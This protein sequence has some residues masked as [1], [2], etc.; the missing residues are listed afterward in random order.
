VAKRVNSSNAPLTACNVPVRAPA[1]INL[2]LHVLGR[3][4]DG[5]HVLDSLMVPIGLYDELTINITSDDQR[6]TKRSAIVVTSDSDAAPDGPTNL[7]YRAAELLLDEVTRSIAVRVHIAKRIPVGSGLG[8]GSSDA[9]AVLL[10]LND[11]LGKPYNTAE[12]AALGGRIGADVSFFVYGR[13]ARVGGIGE[14]ITPLEAW[15]ALP[16]VVCSDG[17]ALSTKL[18]YSKVDLSL[19]RRR[20]DSNITHLVIDREAISALLVNDLEAAAAQIHFEV[21][22]LK[23]RLLEQGALGALMTGSGSAVFGVFGDAKLAQRAAA[24]LRTQGL[25]A[26][27]V[28]TL[29]LSPCVKS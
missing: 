23:A 15:A 25:W 5:Y 13:P 27:A 11:Y 4:D 26:E 7:A 16:L 12:L 10:T 20:P 22:S 17:Y 24:A 14:Q 8:G 3:R 2:S 18:V 9:A 6:A 1:K 21:L 28:N 29:D 19:T